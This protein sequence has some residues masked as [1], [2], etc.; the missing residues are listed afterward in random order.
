MKIAL[1]TD[2]TADLPQQLINQWKIFVLPLKVSFGKEQY[3]DNELAAE[4]FY[5]RLRAESTLPTTSQPTPEDFASLYAKV[6]T[7]Y[8]EIISIHISSGLSGTLNSAHMAA[9]SFRGQ[10]HVV[11][12][13]SISLGIGQQVVEAALGIQEGLAVPAVL[14]RIEKSRENTE[15]IFTL[16]TLEYLHKGGRIGVVKG[17]VGALLRIKPII[18]VNEDG[19]YVPAGIAR[20]LDKSLRGI[21]SAMEKAAAGRTVKSLAIAHGAAPEAAEKLQAMLEAA[22][23]VNASMFTQVGPVIGVHTGPGTVG[24]SL[25]FA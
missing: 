4:E 20:S 24:A 3:L 10:V 7:D 2:S 23:N 9:K 17:M 14:D 8:D 13:R 11:D 19:V 5:S 22:F 1:V 25:V 15:T 6:L 18:R 21:V 16:D 12:S